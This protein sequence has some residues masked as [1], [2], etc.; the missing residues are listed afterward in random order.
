MFF[1]FVFFYSLSRAIIPYVVWEEA[2]TTKYCKDFITILIYILI[3]ALILVLIFF[4]YRE[5]TGYHTV[6]YN[7]VT[8]K[9][10]P[11]VRIVMLSDLHD[12]DVTHDGNSRLLRHIDTIDPDFVIFAGDMITSYMEPYSEPKRAYDFIRRL[13]ASHKVYYGLG[14]HEQRY[15][16]DPDKFPGRF[17]ELERLAT[18]SGAEFLSDR[19]ADVDGKNIRI[20]GYDVPMDNYKRIGAPKLPDDAVCDVFGPVDRDRYNILIAHDPDFFEQYVNWGPDLIL[21]GHLHGG[22]VAVPG[23]GGVISPQLS[24]FPK[25]DFGIYTKNDTTM[26][27]SRGI[28]WHSVPIRIFNKAEI[29]TITISSSSGGE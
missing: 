8:D 7:I 17:E 13:C 29:V 24:L 2:D 1:R 6:E 16:E 26:I 4:I 27:V 25:Y 10:I 19:Y 12:T 23:I 21:S 28:G 20:Y 3:F 9:H 5:S 18:G 11:T 14:N 22:I 15:R